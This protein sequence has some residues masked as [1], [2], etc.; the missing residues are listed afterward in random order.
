MYENYTKDNAKRLRM[1][2]FAL[3]NLEDQMEQ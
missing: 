3:A 2:T 1:T